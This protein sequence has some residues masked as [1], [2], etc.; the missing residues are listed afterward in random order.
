MNESVLTKE[1]AE[2]KNRVKKLKEQTK[3]ERLRKEESE[4]E[5]ELTELKRP[6]IIDWIRRLFKKGG[7][8]NGS[9]RTQT[10]DS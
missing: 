5:R 9:S 3:L 8:G 10:K 1:K 6:S 7:K 4:C 2:T